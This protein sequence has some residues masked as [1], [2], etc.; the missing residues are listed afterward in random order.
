MLQA[1]IDATY[2]VES[3]KPRVH[4]DISWI[5]KQLNSLAGKRNDA[6]HSPL[7]FITQLDAE[8]EMEGVEILPMYFFGNPRAA[9]LKDKSLLQEFKWYRDHLGRLA[10]FAE[11]LH[12]ALAFPDYL[13]PDRPQLPP[14]G[15]F[16]SRRATTRRKNKSK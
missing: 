11:L 3:P 16:R 5:L 8:G 7:I 6:I 9:G 4:A 10:K 2:M 13:W 15:Q 14:V 12:F 1:A